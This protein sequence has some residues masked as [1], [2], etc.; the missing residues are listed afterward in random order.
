MYEFRKPDPGKA[1]P[2]KKPPKYKRF[3]SPKKKIKKIKKNL[4]Y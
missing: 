4:T 1:L 2:T 3:L